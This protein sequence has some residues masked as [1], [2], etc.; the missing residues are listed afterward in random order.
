MGRVFILYKKVLYWGYMDGIFIQEIFYLGYL[1][2]LGLIIRV[3]VGDMIKVYFKNLVIRFF[4]VYFYGI[5]YN[6]VDEGVI[7]VDY[8]NINV[9]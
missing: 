6:K 9:E 5:F 8:V 7:Y 3:E 2:V 4:I 1:G